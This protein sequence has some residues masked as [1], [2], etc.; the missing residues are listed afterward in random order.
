MEARVVT[1]L[2]V[3]QPRFDTEQRPEEIVSVL[4]ELSFGLFETFE[5]EIERLFLGDLFWC[6]AFEAAKVL[7]SS[8]LPFC[9]HRIRLQGENRNCES[10]CLRTFLKRE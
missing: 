8:E 10:G 6:A 3:R 5:F 7:L 1:Q 9:G 4:L 2:D